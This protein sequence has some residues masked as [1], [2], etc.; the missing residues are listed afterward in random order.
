MVR[1]HRTVR[2]SAWITIQ[3]LVCAQAAPLAGAA[4]EPWVL[5]GSVE[6]VQSGL[7]EEFK[8]RGTDQRT[9]LEEDHQGLLWLGRWRNIRKRQ[10]AQQLLEQTKQEAVAALESLRAFY[11]YSLKSHI[12]NPLNN[13]MTPPEYRLRLGQTPPEDFETLREY[14]QLV[15]QESNAIDDGIAA[16]RIQRQ[17]TYVGLALDQRDWGERFGARPVASRARAGLEEVVE[18]VHYR[19][20]PDGLRFLQTVQFQKAWSLRGRWGTLST[21]RGT[22]VLQGTLC[23]GHIVIGTRSEIGGVLT[24][25]VEIGNHVKL[26]GDSNIGFA[27][28]GDWVH[29]QDST[30]RGYAS[31]DDAVVVVKGGAPPDAAALKPEQAD[32]YLDK[33]GVA[34]NTV[35]R[36]STLLTERKKE[37]WSFVAEST[38]PTPEAKTLAK[39]GVDQRRTEVASGAYLLNARIVRNSAIGENAVVLGPGL[40]EHSIVGKGAEVRVNANITRSYLGPGVK[41][42]SEMSKSFVTRGFIS[43]HQAT[44]L[45]LIT[46]NEIPIISREGQL[47]LV[48]SPNPTN[49][50]AGTAFA[51]FSGATAATGQSEKGTAIFLGPV[52]TGVNSSTINLYQH[53]DIP[54]EALPDELGVTVVYAGAL[55]KGHSV[56]GT[57]LPFSYADGPSPKSHKIGWILERDPGLIQTFLRKGLKPEI[58]DGSIRLGLKMIQD[59]RVR[60][61]QPGARQ[62]WTP[63][64]LDAGERIY[65]AALTRLEQANWDPAVLWAPAGLEEPIAQ[66][67]ERALQGL[68]LNPQ[69][70][71]FLER[72]YQR[73]R[74]AGEQAQVELTPDDSE[75]FVVALDR[76]GLLG[77]LGQTLSKQGINIVENHET[78][79]EGTSLGRFAVDADRGRLVGAARIVRMMLTKIDK[80]RTAARRTLQARGLVIPERFRRVKDIPPVKWGTDGVRA[81]TVLDAQKLLTEL[82]Q[83]IAKE[84]LTPADAFWVGALTGLIAAS[85]G[86]RFVAVGYDGGSRP[87]SRDLL[88]A[89]VKGVEAIGGMA[90]FPA[91]TLD[92]LPSI[93]TPDLQQLVAEAQ[94]AVGAYLMVSASHNPWGDGGIKVGLGAGDKLPDVWQSEG[95]RLLAAEDPLLVLADI[96]LRHGLLDA[97]VPHASPA[98]T[99]PDL[100]KILATMVARVGQ[101][102]VDFSYGAPSPSFTTVL[103][104]AHG[105]AGGELRSIAAR[106]PRL[107]DQLGDQLL[108]INRGHVV[109]QIDSRLVVLPEVYEDPAMVGVQE[110]LFEAFRDSQGRV[111]INKVGAT[112]SYRSEKVLEQDE[113][114]EVAGL[115]TIHVVDPGLINQEVGAE[116]VVQHQQWPRAVDVNP[117]TRELYVGTISHEWPASRVFPGDDVLIATADGDADRGVLVV[118]GPDGRPVIIDGDKI[119]AIFATTVQELVKTLH[120]T[121]VQV[122]IVGTIMKDPH[123]EEWAKAHFPEGHVKTTQVGDQPASEGAKALAAQIHGAVVYAEQNGHVNLHFDPEVRQELAALT[124]TILRGR[125]V[126]TD[127]EQIA[128]RQLRGLLNF[129]NPVGGSGVRNLLLLREIMV[130]KGWTPTMLPTLFYANTHVVHLQLRPGP[131][132]RID[133]SGLQYADPILQQGILG[134]QE[135]VIALQRLRGTYGM[136]KDIVRKSGTAEMLRAH[137]WGPGDTPEDRA[138]FDEAVQTEL[139]PVLKRLFI[140][141]VTAAAGLEELPAYQQVQGLYQQ[142]TGR[143]P[144]QFAE[145][146]RRHAGAHEVEP[147]RVVE[148]LAAWDPQAL[149]QWL[150]QQADRRDAVR[151][152]ARARVVAFHGGIAGNKLDPAFAQIEDSLKVS[153]SIVNVGA[154]YDSGGDTQRWR[155]FLKQAFVGVEAA[156]EGDYRNALGG[157]MPSRRRELLGARLGDVRV[158]DGGYEAAMRDRLAS[159]R[160]WWQE[161][162]DAVWI[163]GQLLGAMR[164]LDAWAKRHPEHQ[165]TLPTHRVAVGNAVAVASKLQLNVYQA[166]A[167]NVA[168]ARLA[169]MLDAAIWAVR[170]TVAAMPV[171]NGHADLYG[172]YAAELGAG[173]VQGW[174]MDLARHYYTVELAPEYQQKSGRAKIIVRDVAGNPDL[175][176]PLPDLAVETVIVPYLE[177]AGPRATL[178]VGEGEYGDLTE[179][180]KDERLIFHGM[181]ATAGNWPTLAP[182]VVEAVRHASLV[183][184]GPG[185]WGP[186]VL[187]HLYTDGLV[188]LLRERR[189]AD[190][191]FR[192][193]VNLNVS[194]DYLTY[195][196]TVLQLL[197]QMELVMGIVTGDRHLAFSDVVTDVVIPKFEHPQWTPDVL[198]A[199]AVATGQSFDNIEGQAVGLPRY[200]EPALVS[201]DELQQIATAF[202]GVN[203]IHEP[204]VTI[205]EEVSSSAGAAT[206]QRGTVHDPAQLAD[207]VYGPMVAQHLGVAWPGVAVAAGFEE[208]AVPSVVAAQKVV[209]LGPEA[210]RALEVLALIRP[211]DGRPIP[212]VAIVEN[213]RQAAAAHAD[214]EALGYAPEDAGRWIINLAERGITVR[215]AVADASAHYLAQGWHPLVVRTLDAL[216]EVARFLGVPEPA[217][218]VRMTQALI[219][220]ALEQVYQ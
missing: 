16:R 132:Q 128:A 73:Y 77:I 150:G 164:A 26:H 108:E 182:E 175:A 200:L 14:L 146:V 37:A 193:V 112:G 51:N 107:S 177:A 204:L 100:S 197:R 160:G 219:E 163:A 115:G 201:D 74:R 65:Q 10:R 53:P 32:R 28:I 2:L 169:R 36:G 50:G 72:L 113:T 142:T 38:P 173:R 42:G 211:A 12:P 143:T 69:H 205:A 40:I 216:E 168:N 95:N 120:A 101:G 84:A 123:A 25:H 149:R 11:A 45:S 118:V 140:R 125:A 96:A 151:R 35:I 59:E 117:V 188:Q 13:S 20:D 167:I 174:V 22:V 181:K 104:E 93:T 214:L 105:S 198:K 106:V 87:G 138:R 184:L 68:Q 124:N 60:M 48:D 34:Y 141:P 179:H 58:I 27:R 46:T 195:G 126:S 210:L 114:F 79:F 8:K 97:I 166:N 130:I 156:A 212:V 75:L 136:E 44:Y 187:A 109:L 194:H 202:P 137:L 180:R 147:A 135:L 85:H 170:D 148:G 218:F 217:T 17:L 189:Q 3:A 192:V 19:L 62:R 209:I 49:I 186:S 70:R 139:K 43:E 165:G 94:G 56:K 111:V 91:D 102:L 89:A 78:T 88:Q 67:F 158:F 119:A 23:R 103:D 162:A 92:Q 155:E 133:L 145:E 90:V 64:Q 183:T 127:E 63:E 98:Q 191:A 215:E 144:E 213:A 7:E 57:V 61:Q 18:G 172:I 129:F 21:G 24:Q 39:Y 30:L 6:G 66:G 29:L 178:M 199:H 161:D 220:R 1:L 15:I 154:S 203:V 157:P 47:V 176:F 206:V 208:V 31:D 134:P 116:H 82:A 131:G 76:P 190:P 86:S 55:I 80:E 110:G 171:S 122:G 9:G 54:I 196:S 152:G 121:G 33:N 185:S 83:G 207:R 4:P 52:F 153:V 41:V 71:G 81:R 159:R 5:R 99:P